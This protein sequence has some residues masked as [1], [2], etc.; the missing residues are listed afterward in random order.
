MTNKTPVSDENPGVQPVVGP[1]VAPNQ[2]FEKRWTLG[3][4]PDAI[5]KLKIVVPGL[6][7]VSHDATRPSS[8]RISSDSAEILEHVE[9]SSDGPEIVRVRAKGYMNGHLL[10]EVSLQR[11][12]AIHSLSCAGSATTVV[13]DGVLLNNDKQRSLELKATGSGDVFVGSSVPIQVNSMH[14]N[15]G[16]SGDVQVVAPAIYCKAETHIRVQASGDVNV[17]TNDLQ[18]QSAHLEVSGSG[19]VNVEV[20]NAFDVSDK[21][22]TSIAGSGKVNAFCRSIDA[23]TIASAIAGSGNSTVAAWEKLAAS[24]MKTDIAGSGNV[25]VAC[26]GAGVTSLQEINIAGCGNVDLADV[27]A[28]TARIS[29]AGSGNVAL[30]VGAEAHES[31]FGSGDVEYVGGQPR[32]VYTSGVRASYASAHKKS[33]VARPL[34]V[35]LGYK[36]RFPSPIPL[37]EAAFS[38]IRACHASIDGSAIKSAIG[39]LF[40]AFRS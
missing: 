40:N 38:Q 1:R 33:H 37:R 20:A 25:T 19:D 35:S 27:F 15:R 7:Y 6:V 9:I 39:S 34:A 4:S 18:S 36:Q 30:R 21:L 31:F 13:E 28:D 5:E 16:G 11:A 8:V 29:V 24:T 12:S 32:E 10:T 2:N 22:R 3:K 23:A 14:I 17:F 26:G